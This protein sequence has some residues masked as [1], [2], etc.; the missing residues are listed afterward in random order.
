[1]KRRVPFEKETHQGSA[2]VFE[3]QSSR[4]DFNL[5]ITR[6]IHS[7]FKFFIIFQILFIVVCRCQNQNDAI[8]GVG[9]EALAR[10]LPRGKQAKGDLYW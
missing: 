1:M 6:I 4:L 7:R 5:R 2:M 10:P 8:N 9:P 3:K